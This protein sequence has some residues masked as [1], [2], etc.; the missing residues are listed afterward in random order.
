MESDQSYIPQLRNVGFTWTLI[1]GRLLRR[2][3]W[4]WSPHRNPPLLLEAGWTRAVGV[5]RFA[6]LER[7]RRNQTSGVWLTVTS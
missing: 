5:K 6:A 1:S 3:V 2:Q 7:H 4:R